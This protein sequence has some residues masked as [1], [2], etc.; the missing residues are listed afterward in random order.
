MVINHSLSR[1]QYIY[2]YDWGPNTGANWFFSSE[3]SLI[4]FTYSLML[5]QLSKNVVL[6]ILPKKHILLC[7]HITCLLSVTSLSR[8][9]LS[10]SIILSNIT[11]LINLAR[12]DLKTGA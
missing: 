2:Y 11:V 7:P 5:K 3:E 1:R 4:D 6:F 10:I 9:L 12:W 8:F